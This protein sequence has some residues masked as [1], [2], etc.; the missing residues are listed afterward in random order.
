MERLDPLS[1]LS[2][3]DKWYLGGGGRLLWA[4]PFPVFLDRPGFWDKAHYY[5]LEFQPLFTWTLLDEQGCEIELRSKLRDW[6]P[7]R[8]RQRFSPPLAGVAVEEQKCVLPN[9]VACSRVTLKNRSRKPLQLHFVAWTAQGTYPSKHSTWLTDVEH[10]DGEI[11]FDK[12]IRQGERPE[13]RFSA[14]FGVKAKTKSFAINL[15]EGSLPSPQWKLTPFYEQF[16]R[17]KLSNSIKLQG[18]N[19]DGLLFMALH[20]TVTVK[21]GQQVPIDVA[22]AAATSVHEAR[23]NLRVAFESE[24]P[25]R[26]SEMNWNDHFSSVPYFECSDQYLTHYY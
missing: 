9:D 24:S 17:R 21:P 13:F 12:H 1:L 18:I 3:N 16:S 14:V 6:T 5:N 26:L 25:I 7:A 10:R 19:S 4:P 2:R 8:V 11:A 20:A 22:L 15:S 23:Q